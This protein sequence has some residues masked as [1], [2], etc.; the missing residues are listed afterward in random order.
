LL[1]NQWHILQRNVQLENEK[2][3]FT[4]KQLTNDK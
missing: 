4:N 2:I 3:I 1:I